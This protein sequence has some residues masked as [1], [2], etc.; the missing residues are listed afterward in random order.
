MTFIIKDVY[1]VKNVEMPS[2]LVP[3]VLISDKYRIDFQVASYFNASI[4]VELDKK[5][6]PSTVTEHST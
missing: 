6:K 2:F 1:F 3:E 5:K 4:Y